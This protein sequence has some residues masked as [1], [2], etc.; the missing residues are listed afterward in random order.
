MADVQIPPSDAKI[1]FTIAGKV[2]I[3]HISSDGKVSTPSYPSSLFMFKLQSDT[4]ITFLQVGSWVYPIVPGKSPILKSSEGSY[5]FPDLDENQIGNAVGLIL[6]AD[7]LDIEKQE[8]EHFLE[9]LSKDPRAD[10]KEYEECLEYSTQVSAGLVK[11][12]EYVGRGM[13][14]G[15][16]NLL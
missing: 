4:E 2:Q 1:L 14:K 9:E 11:G 16:M 13:V 8:F 10:L 15:K 12:A 3:F 7:I 6:P 5:M